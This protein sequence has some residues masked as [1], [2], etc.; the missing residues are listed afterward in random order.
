[1]KKTLLSLLI[2][3]ASST[4]FAFDLQRP[5]NNVVDDLVWTGHLSPDT[6]SMTSALAAAFIYGGTAVVPEPIN[7]ESQFVVDYCKASAPMVL[8]DFSD[9]KIGLVD[10]N[11]QTQLHETVNQEDI[12]AIIDHHTIAGKPVETSHVTAMDIRAWGSAATILADIAEKQGVTFDTVTACTT[13]AGILSDTVIFQSATT[14]DYDREH[15]EKLAKVAGIKDINAFGQEM[16]N[17]KSDLKNVA[18]EDILTM[19]YKTFEYGGKQVGIGVAETL[20]AQEL[21]DRHDEFVAAMKAHK[22][23]TGLD[24][25]FF[26]VTDTK[27][28]RANLMWID[29]SDALVAEQAFALKSDSEWLRLDGVTSRKRQIGPAIQKAVEKLNK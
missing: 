18:A 22:T 20:T 4:A 6:D 14:T 13:L 10:F 15:A 5:A 29:E 11:Q 12:V 16:L 26:S 2:L 7:P 23:A 19:D 24:H 9:K 3:S 1:M 17:A 21:L 28:K 25:L 8:N 27:H